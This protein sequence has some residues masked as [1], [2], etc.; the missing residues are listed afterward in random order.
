[1]ESISASNREQPRRRAGSRKKL[2]PLKKV[3][4]FPNG[5]PDV[6]KL[7]VTELM[8]MTIS[9]SASMPSNNTILVSHDR[10]KNHVEDFDNDE[11]M[12]GSLSPGRGLSSQRSYGNISL[13]GSD[14]SSSSRLTQQELLNVIKI[15]AERKLE[16]P[17]FVT[18]IEQLPPM[19]LSWNNKL[20]PNHNKHRPQVNIIGCMHPVELILAQADQ[21]SRHQQETLTAKKKICE[22]K[23]KQIDDAIQLKYTR[24]ERYALAFE[25]KQRQIEWLKIIKL[26]IYFSTLY[27]N[28][29]RHILAGAFFSHSVNAAYVIRQACKGFIKRHLLHKFKFKFMVLFRKREFHFRL[30]MRIRRKRQA[31]AKI[32]TFL[33]EFRNHHQVLF[34]LSFSL[35]DMFFQH[36]IVEFSV[37]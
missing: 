9:K 11:S 8:Q 24:A 1:M 18:P 13:D 10:I 4:S 25:R 6:G 3:K 20:P 19:H 30:G 26:S 5:K 2:K 12:Y 29:R 35:Y 36:S 7:P 23:V 28:V 32:K 21:R 31:I 27:A 22:D 17:A 14:Y 37:Q 33:T 34:M 15:R 16:P